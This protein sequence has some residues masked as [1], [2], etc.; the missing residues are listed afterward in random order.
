MADAAHTARKPLV[1][2][3]AIGVTASIV[4]GVLWNVHA[5]ENTMALHILAA[6][7]ASGFVSFLLVLLVFAPMAGVQ[8][9][10]QTRRV[11]RRRSASR[12]ESRRG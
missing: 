4:G 2:G 6:F 10:L 11:D 9:Y 5:D 1:W 7:A 8:S 3:I 12:P